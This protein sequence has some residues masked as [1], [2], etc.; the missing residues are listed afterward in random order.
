MK[1]T[2]I[3]FCSFHVGQAWK[4][5]LEKIGLKKCFSNTNSERG[6]LLRRI[7]GL[8]A[9][10]EDLLAPCFYEVFQKSTLATAKMRKFFDYMETFYIKQNCKYPI[11]SWAN[12]TSM[13]IESTT[14]GAESYHALFTFPKDKPNIFLF[15]EKLKKTE[16]DSERKGRSRNTR[17]NRTVKHPQ[18]L[19]SLR[20]SSITFLEFLDVA[21]PS[22]AR[23]S[24]ART[25]TESTK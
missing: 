24:V 25:E 15:L 4:K 17:K 16:R 5:K 8:K 3:R 23:L 7:F 1:G 18:L 14:N 22:M 9:L 19:A 6:R 12:V 20:S 10:D 21:S 2:E 13:D 11:H